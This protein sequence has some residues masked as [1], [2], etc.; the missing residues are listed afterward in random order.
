MPNGYLGSPPK[1]LVKNEGLHTISEVFDLQSK[2][3][4]DGSLKLITSGSSDNSA[5]TL[6]FNDCLPAK[7]ARRG[8][9]CQT[10]PKD[11]EKFDYCY[12]KKNSKQKIITK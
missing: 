2:G 1:Q 5:Q 4:W 11:T 3:H 6:E 7:P 12:K 9:W 10:D 8:F